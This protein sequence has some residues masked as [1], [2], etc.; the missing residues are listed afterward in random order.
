VIYNDGERGE[1]CMTQETETNCRTE[2]LLDYS[3]QD[4]TFHSIDYHPESCII[5]FGTNKGLILNYK[6][7]VGTDAMDFYECDDPLSNKKCGPIYVNDKEVREDN[8]TIVFISEF[9]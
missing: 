3:F 5:S 6:I 8:G 9:E 7:M 4:I 1:D 2:C